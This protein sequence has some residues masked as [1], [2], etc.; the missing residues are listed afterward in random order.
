M[1]RFGISSALI[2]LSVLGLSGSGVAGAA[3]Q[4]QSQDVLVGTFTVRE[5]AP[6]WV[7]V[8]FDA[9]SIGDSTLTLVS[10]VHPGSPAARA[11]LRR[12]DRV[13]R[14]NGTF[15]DV[16]LIE[17]LGSR[18]RPG[19]PY[20]FDV[21]RGG[22]TLA[23]ALVAEQGPGYPTVIQ[24]RMQSELDTLARLI[25]VALDSLQVVERLPQLTVRTQ[26][27]EQGTVTLVVSS[28]ADGQVPSPAT[29]VRASAEFRP[30]PATAPGTIVRRPGAV[31]AWNSTS[32]LG[33]YAEGARRVAGA[34]LHRVSPDLGRYLGVD[35]GLLVTAVAPGSPAARS[36]LRPGDVLLAVNGRDVDTLD[37]FRKLLGFPSAQ[38]VMSIQRRG[39]PLDLELRR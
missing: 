29:T 19:D 9:V 31:A 35:R 32:A 30:D 37:S 34:E 1:K 16:R 2:A 23:L 4:Q 11:G 12:G 38:S 28:A 10:Y 26:S 15:A 25:S 27:A 5:A 3:Y 14:V 7:G 24:A 20:A 6:G 17:L 18:I 33:T 13:L 39:E 8:G 36:S 22:D 21:L